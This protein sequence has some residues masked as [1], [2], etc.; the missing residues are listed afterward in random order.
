MQFSSFQS[1][2]VPQKQ[3][4]KLSRNCFR[5]VSYLCYDKKDIGNI[6]S[7]AECLWSFPSIHLIEWIGGKQVYSVSLWRHSTSCLIVSFVKVLV[8]QCLS[9]HFGLQG[10]GGRCWDEEKD[11]KAQ[12]TCSW[13]QASEKANIYTWHFQALQVLMVQHI[14]CSSVV[15][16]CYKKPSH[17]YVFSGCNGSLNHSVKE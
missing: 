16:T 3:W 14:C 4:K 1:Q 6:T 13:T 9:L 2:L 11:R 15:N 7:Q 5:P 12:T 10:G 17:H 8:L